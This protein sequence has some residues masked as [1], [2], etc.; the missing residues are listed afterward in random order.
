[1]I[2]LD[3][4]PDRHCRCSSCLRWDRFPELADRLLHCSDQR[5]QL[6]RRQGMIS[7]IARDDLCYGAQINALG[8]VVAVHDAS[9]PADPFS[10]PLH[11]TNATQEK[12]SSLRIHMSRSSTKSSPIFRQ[13]SCGGNRRIVADCQQRSCRR[14]Y[15]NVAPRFGKAGFWLRR[16]RAS[17]SLY[18]LGADLGEQPVKTFCVLDAAK[19][20][21]HLDKAK[22]LTP[23]SGRGSRPGRL[24]PADGPRGSGKPPTQ[25]FGG[26][27]GRS[28]GKAAI[29]RHGLSP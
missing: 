21:G 5:G 7:D 12:H 15:G 22:K 24:I 26:D 25:L 9:L 2:A 14:G 13:L 4:S 28:V 16:T 10:L 6:I 27:A 8:C 19:L 29:W 18:R 3:R 23:G 20:A 11:T 1:M 17:S